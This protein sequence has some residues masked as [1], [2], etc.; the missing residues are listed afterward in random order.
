MNRN[1]FCAKALGV[2]LLTGGCV[3]TSDPQISPEFPID[4]EG[5]G[6]V[7]FPSANEVPV[8]YEGEHDVGGPFDGE[9]SILDEEL[10][11]VA[12]PPESEVRSTWSQFRGNAQK[13][14]ATHTPGPATTLKWRR[15][16]LGSVSP[17]GIS[18]SPNGDVYFRTTDLGQY[19]SVFRLS[20][21]DGSV[22]AESR[23]IPAGDGGV[24]LVGELAMVTTR[25]VLVVFD[26]ESLEIVQEIGSLD[27]AELV[28]TPVPAAAA[29]SPDE[30]LKVFVADR[31]T[32]MIHMIDVDEG[33]RIWSYPTARNGWLFELG[34][35]FQ[36]E[37][38]STA[39]AYFGNQV[40]A[41]GISVVDRGAD[42]G[43]VHWE[44][45]PQGFNWIG[46]GILN[47]EFS[48][49]YVT[50]FADNDSDV[51]WAIDA[52]NGRVKWSL[53]NDFGARNFFGRPVLVE[54]RVYASGFNGLVVA[55]D[56]SNL[57][58]SI[59]W[60]FRPPL[61]EFAELTGMSAAVTDEGE[62]FLYAVDQGFDS[63]QLIILRDAGD[64][65]DMIFRTDLVKSMKRGF[66]ANNAPSIGP[67]GCVLIGSGVYDDPNG[68]EVYCF[69]PQGSVES[70]AHEGS[71]GGRR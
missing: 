36:T 25:N 23:P 56:D 53:P 14:G 67:D 64:S 17:G 59:A 57:G 32:A 43:D 9:I 26:M 5:E 29:V 49:I 6:I 44:G 42:D 41:P 21:V 66:L 68:G 46:T 39:V 62:I 54:N 69:C 8:T 11:D 3:P 16:G 48:H 22:I 31:A 60:E 70:S 20:G 1:D 40:E 45:G 2:A 63:A 28:G 10:A 13:T 61:G 65:V 18:I 71:M 12:F 7:A 24:T 51:L 52:M 4:V 15:S 30:S 35:V 34:P 47:E 55:V 27:F 33:R 19:S 50:T 38:G 37:E 58:A